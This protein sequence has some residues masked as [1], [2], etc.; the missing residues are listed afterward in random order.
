MLT[1]QLPN[2]PTPARITYQVPL[3][4]NSLIAVSALCDADCEVT[5]DKN[6][7]MVEHQ[8]LGMVRYILT[9]L[10]LILLTNTPTFILPPTQTSEHIP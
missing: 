4:H 5:F 1:L 6:M 9:G 3:I 7:V 2:I 8:G 10:W